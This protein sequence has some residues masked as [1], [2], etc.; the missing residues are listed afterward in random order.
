MPEL[1]A[2]DLFGGKEK[3]TKNM[4]RAIREALFRT[5][6]SFINV[7]R[8][9]QNRGIDMETILKIVKEEWQDVITFGLF[10]KLEGPLRLSIHKIL[11]PPNLDDPLVM[12][13]WENE[14]VHNKRMLLAGML[15]K[16]DEQTKEKNGKNKRND[17][18]PIK[19]YVML[20]AVEELAS[21]NE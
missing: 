6:D 11:G 15:A 4:G 2:L 7:L 17:G 21:E 1:R 20:R 8:M 14:R 13:A 5:E 12:K 9:I 18:V 16:K 3:I 10:Q 19:L